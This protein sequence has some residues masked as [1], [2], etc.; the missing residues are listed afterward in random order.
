MIEERHL[1][2]ET[3]PVKSRIA[4]SAGDA[5]TAI[6]QSLAAAGALTYY[7]VNLRGLNANLAGI[8]WL[9]FGIWN[10]VNDPL[11]GYISDRTKH[12]LGR[13]IP[14]IRYGAPIFA[15]GFIAFW[16]RIPGTDGNQT[17]LFIQL[18]L[19]LFVY[20]ILYTAIA[21]S[22]WVL[23]YEI[24][25]SNKAR[26]SIYVWKILFMVFT[27]VVPFALEATIKPEVG[28]M[29]GISRFRWVLI[30]LGV[31]MTLIVF[32]STYFFKENHYAKAEEQFDFIKSFKACFTNRSFVVFE[33]L[34]FT[35]IF[36]QT[37][38][39]QGIW[40]YFDV[41]AMPRLPLLVALGLGIVLG[42]LAWI[43]WRDRWGIKFCAQLFTLAFAIGCGL[44]TVLGRS[45]LFATGGFFLFGVGFSGGMYLIPLM[46]GDVVDMDEHRT[47]LR[48]EG[49]YAGINSFI[50]KPA[51]S[52]AMWALLTLMTA[53]GYNDKLPAAAQSYEAG[54]G[55]L[56]GWG[57]P[58]GVLLLLSFIALFF[59]PLAGAEWTDI[60]ARLG[61][62]HQEKERAY[63]E[64]LGYKFME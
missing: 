22:F 58:A 42:V 52:I 14:Y 36:V 2:E 11:F 29:A 34:S 7:F 47:G 40:Y 28:D 1:Q 39:M 35:I 61:V 60:K 57:G 55:V 20:D 63:L 3:V 6:L 24:A 17:A 4:I 62:V 8:V 15:L 56:V 26:G 45:V 53:Y 31:V 44:I 12:E 27:I 21:T 64:K 43:R 50:T 18:L 41:L 51:I 46:N 9:L 54:T 5:A 59:Y 16:V 33:V 48:R 38:L 49:M 23:P 19:A 32:F 30:G 37:A 13:R 10:A 25:V